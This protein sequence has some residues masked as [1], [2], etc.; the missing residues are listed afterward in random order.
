MADKY[1]HYTPPEGASVTITW[2][3][4]PF[5]GHGKTKTSALSK[6]PHDFSQ[7]D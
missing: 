6:I 1:L 4:Q 3:Q 7:G 2:R 5:I